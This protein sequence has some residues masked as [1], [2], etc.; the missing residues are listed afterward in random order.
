MNNFYIFGD[1]HAS[2]F[3][4]FNNVV[5]IPASSAKGLANKNSKTKTNITI[6]KLLKNIENNSNL[7]FFFG[8]VDMDFILNYKY[9][10]QSN[11]E[12]Y[13]IFIIKI[14]HSYINFIK[15]NTLNQNV[16]ICELPIS[17]L[18]DQQLLSVIKWEGH[19]NNINSHLSD[20]NKNI[21]SNF[22]KVIP[23]QT[24]LKYYS[25]FNNELQNICNKTGFKILEINKYF[26]HASGTY[27]IPQKYLKNTVDHH[28][29]HNIEEL[30]L[31]SLNKFYIK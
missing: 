16:F 19:M 25:I 30:Y 13:E 12:N 17:H 9:N 31:K 1:S 5:S 26:K 8:K 11:F 24:H 21:Y 27:H 20:E 3:Q 2:C 29:K 15:L 28:L 14:V 6:V 18:S 23:F 7:I 10:T 4:N 22:N